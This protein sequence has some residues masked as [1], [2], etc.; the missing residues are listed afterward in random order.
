[1]TKPRSLAHCHVG[2]IALPELPESMTQRCEC[3]EH[4]VCCLWQKCPRWSNI[5]RQQQTQYE[6]IQKLRGHPGIGVGVIG[7]LGE[8]S[9]G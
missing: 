3:P 9:D 2:T 6:Q 8:R 4:W 5:K 7:E 1:M